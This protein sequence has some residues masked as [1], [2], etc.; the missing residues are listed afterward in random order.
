MVCKYSIKFPKPYG[1]GRREYKD[2]YCIFHCDKEN[3][4]SEEIEEFNEK[5][6]KEY[7][8]QRK[9]EAV[10][11]FIGFKFPDNFS[12]IKIKFEK[13][14]NFERATFGDGAN[15]QSVTFGDGAY[16]RGATFGS[17]AYY[18]DENDLFMGRV[19]FSYTNFEYPDTIEFVDVNLSKAKFLHC[20]NIDKIGRFEKIKWAKKG[21]R[22]AVYDESTVMRQDC[23]YVAEIYRKLRLNYEKNLR[24]SE[25]GDFYIG[26]MEM[27]RK[28]VKL[29]GRE[30][31]NKILNLIFRNI[32]LIA[33]YRN[34]S[35]YGEN[36][37]LPVV[38]MFLITLV[39]AFYYY[40]PGDFFTGFDIHGICTSHFLES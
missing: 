32:S 3:F 23:E 31:K 40:S 7:E 21:G 17:E 29:V 11:N 6:W 38:W 37:F 36:Y 14:V 13:P 5:F 27:R 19:D 35:Y 26:E 24:F 28:S 10:F 12:F 25:A 39:F 22:K 16:F 1:C 34:F 9:R 15:F 2:R 8:K 33:W 30:I 4:E 18:R 20:L